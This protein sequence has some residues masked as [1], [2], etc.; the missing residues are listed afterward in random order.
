[1]EAMAKLAAVGVTAVVLSAVLR[2][3]TPELALLLVL[4][5]GLWML[6]L[7]AQGLGAAVA[8]ME[9]LAQLAGLSEALLE[10]VFKTVALSI[11]TRLTVEICR[12]AGEGG[13]AA[14]VETAGTVL[15][16]LAALPLVR[17]VAQLM[18]ELLT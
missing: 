12:S 10:P 15:A 11:L 4:A 5:A 16:L 14:F 1:M 6:A 8:L 3:N 2:K 13:A 17:A 18:G 7:A 9:E